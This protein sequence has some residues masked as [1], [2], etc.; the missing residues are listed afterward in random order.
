[1]AYLPLPT[2]NCPRLKSVFPSSIFRLST[3]AAFAPLASLATQT[4]P[5]PVLVA[6]D[7]VQ[8]FAQPQQATLQV[9]ADCQNMH[10]ASYPTTYRELN[11]KNEASTTSAMV[12]PFPVVDY[13]GMY[14]FCFAAIRF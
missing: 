12:L 13:F 6:P 10:P 7:V 4:S 11:D 1:M 9:L 14:S 8:V 3:I 5:A 2:Y